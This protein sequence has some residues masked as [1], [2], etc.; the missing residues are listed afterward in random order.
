M[1]GIPKQVIH[2]LSIGNYQIQATSFDYMSN[3]VHFKLESYFNYMPSIWVTVIRHPNL[4]TIVK[5]SVLSPS[6]KLS[7][8]AEREIE[9]IVK[10]LA[11]TIRVELGKQFNENK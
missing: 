5:S 8:A 1:G 2:E 11:L 4:I 7:P 3:T 9:N 6:W 10:D